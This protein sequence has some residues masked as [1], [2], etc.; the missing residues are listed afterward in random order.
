MDCPRCERSTLMTEMHFEIEVDICSNCHGLW[1][2]YHE[3]DQLEDQAFDQ[4]DMKGTMVYAKRDS[5]ISCPKC[6]HL[7]NTFNYR[8]YDLA[9][10]FCDNG[11]GFWL[12]HGE[13]KRVLELMQKRVKDLKRSVSA[14]NE[15]TNFLKGITSRRGSGSKSVFKRMKGWFGSKN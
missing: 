3:M 4:D 10:D 8:A 15:W 11:H 7:M 14:E 1:L 13:E 2:D 9:I 5:D 12:D 6:R